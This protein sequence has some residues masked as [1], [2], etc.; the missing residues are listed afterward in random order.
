MTGYRIFAGLMAA[1]AVFTAAPAQAGVYTHTDENGVVHIEDRPISPDS[2]LLLTTIKKPKG[3]RKPAA[4]GREYAPVVEKP[5]QRDGLPQALLMAVIKTESNFN[6]RALSPKG[7]AGLMQLMPETWKRYGVEDPFD[8]AQNIRAGAAY[9]KEQFDRFKELDLAL[10]A[11]NAG[12]GSVVKHGG[13]P[14]F[15]ETR[16]YIE[17]VRFYYDHFQKKGDLVS[18]PGAAGVFDQGSEALDRGDFRR[19]AARF[20]VVV[21]KYPKSPEAN[22]NLA[23]SH[24]LA[25]KTSQAIVYYKRAL[26]FDPY[27]KEAYYNLAIIYEKMGRNTQALRIWRRYLRFEVR[28]EETREIEAYITELGQLC[29]E[30]E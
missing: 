18:L 12:P 17:K 6:P 2:R 7:A 15:E 9:L 4:T 26:A 13:V 23:L 3:F 30:K 29:R 24:E 21:N 27:F 11:Y 1:L 20:A 19:A 8:P 5:A 14:P 16:K 22:Y 10:A 25:G 28:P